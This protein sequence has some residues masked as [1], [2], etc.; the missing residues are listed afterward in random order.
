M[1]TRLLV[2]ALLGVGISAFAL[3]YRDDPSNN[4][5]DTEISV[6][7]QVFSPEQAKAA[8]IDLFRSQPDAF[9]VRFN[10]DEY[11]QKPLEDCGNGQYDSGWFWIDVPR[12]SFKLDLVGNDHAVEYK[13]AFRYEDDRWVAAIT[14]QYYACKSGK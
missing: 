4:T 8:L 6:D 3:G 12:T 9:V 1:W 14:G 13:G 7:T 10:P 11:A 5:P 2:L